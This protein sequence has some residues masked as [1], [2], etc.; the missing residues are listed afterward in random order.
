MISTWLTRASMAFL[1]LGGLTLLF[2]ADEILPRLIPGFPAGG[3]WLGQF[4]AAAWIALGLLNWFNQ[5]TLLGGIYGRPVVMTNAVFYFIAATSLVKI[6]ARGELSSA[7][8]VV[9]VLMT[10]FAIAYVWLLFR[11]PLERDIQR[12][13]A[14][15]GD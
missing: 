2:A 9:A 4:L 3:A 13:R 12:R 11:G 5:Q 1:L 10:L 14:S 6:A 7:A 15:G 8:W